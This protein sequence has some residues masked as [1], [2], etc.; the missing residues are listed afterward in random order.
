MKLLKGFLIAIVG[1]FVFITL[2]SLLMPSKVITVR[3]VN[4][5]VPADKIMQEIGDLNN[6]K[7]WHPLFKNDSS[8]VVDPSTAEWVTNNKKNRLQITGR[9][10]NSLQFTLERPGENEILNK[11]EL[12]NYTD[13]NSIDVEWS[14]LTKM[15]WYPWEKFS[16]IF[17]DKM[18]GPGYEAAL[19]ELKIYVEGN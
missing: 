5:H 10:Q 12:I 15:K 19:K 3:S 18:T 9:S 7:N 17:V 1:L 2:L 13:S 11:I 16:G 4:M 8:I 6:W 14:A